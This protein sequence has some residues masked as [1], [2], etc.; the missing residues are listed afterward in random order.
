MVPDILKEIPDFKLKI[1]YGWKTFVLGYGDNPEQMAWKRKM[2]ELMRQPGV[3]ELGRITKKELHRLHQESAVHAYY[4]TFEEI[5]CISVLEA[6]LNGNYPVT[7]DYAALIETNI[8]GE[9]IKGEVRDEKT[10]EAYKQALI[11]RLKRPKSPDYLKTMSEGISEGYQ[12]QKIA[13]L[14]T[15]VFKKGKK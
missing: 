4:C 6:Q 10:A 5:N 8:Y 12:V 9:R 7:T 3:E 13:K 1:A 14:W 11:S 15:D 2:E